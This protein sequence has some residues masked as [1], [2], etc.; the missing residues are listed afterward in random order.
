MV[1]R[2]WFGVLALRELASDQARAGGRAGPQ[3]C[4]G[5]LFVHPGVRGIEGL[6]WG[7]VLAPGRGHGTRSHWEG[8]E[9]ATGQG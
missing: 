6:L 5:E 9:E 4:S 8:S 2:L 7:R 3:E 1:W